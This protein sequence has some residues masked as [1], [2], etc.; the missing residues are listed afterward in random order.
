MALDLNGGPSWIGTKLDSPIIVN[1]TAKEYY[2]QPK[3]YT[4]GHF[5]KF[6]VPNSV[7]VGVNVANSKT[8]FDV[9]AFERPDNATVVVALNRNEAAVLVHLEDSKAGKIEYSVGGHSIVTF[10]WWN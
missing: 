6:I 3:F 4:F 7:R 1:A 9:I 10:I 8:N 5:T 2:K